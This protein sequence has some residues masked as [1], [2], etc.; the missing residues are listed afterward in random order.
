MTLRAPFPYYG[1]KRR[2]AAAIW[3]RL[4]N[5]TVYVEPFAGS[6][7]VLLARPDG[8]GPR[9]IVCDLDGGIANF[10]RAVAA[11]PL[12][13]AHWAD[14]PTIHQDLQA[15]HGWLRE[16]LAEHRERL[17]TDPHYYDAKVAGWWVW[18]ASLWIGRGWCVP[19]GRPLE[20]RSHVNNKGGG[21]GVAAQARD[22][23][24]RACSSGG[25]QG[26]SAQRTTRPDL[27]EWF[28]ALQG[29]LK[30]VVVLNR[31]WRS[32]LTPTLL[33]Q[34][35]SS[36]KSPVGVLLD[37]PYL[38]DSRERRLYSS[39]LAGSSDQAARQCYDWAL[40]HG[41][42]FRIAY[43]CHAGDFDVPPGWDVLETSFTGIRREDRRHRRDLVMFSPACLSK[44]EQIRLL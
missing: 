34:T 18:G 23:R 19:E 12:E 27:L 35:P 40:Q 1:A 37:P 6:C 10:W 13:V 28:V 20:Q 16:W 4:G 24:P 15:R 43:C 39:D 9:E 36:P 11:D 5:P 3:E 31:D 38:T 25:G 30:A 8:A 41:D 22:Q 17:T 33:Q 26:V 2:L 29:R 42:R 21:Q 44:V 14:W 7:A 32:A